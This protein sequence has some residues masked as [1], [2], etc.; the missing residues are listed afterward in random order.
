MEKAQEMMKE[1][2]FSIKDIAYDLGFSSPAYFSTVFK[3][4]NG[5]SPTS[6]KKK[7]T[8]Q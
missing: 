2:K 8:S 7:S 1:G 4:Y 5:Y 3:Q 6:Y